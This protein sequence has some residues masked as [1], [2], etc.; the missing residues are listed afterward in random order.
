[1]TVTGP[2]GLAYDPLADR[3][4]EG[5]DAAINYMMVATKA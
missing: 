1:M 5:Q 4:S 3:W 2:F